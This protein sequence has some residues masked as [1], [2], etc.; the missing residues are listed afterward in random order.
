[1]FQSFFDAPGGFKEELHELS[2][3]AGTEYWYSGQFAIRA[4]YFYEH[5]TK[6]N[7][8][9]FSLG[10]GLKYNVFNLDFAYLIPSAG[11]SNPLANTMRFSLSFEFERAKRGRK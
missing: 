1:M 4:G 11:Q 8:K 5:E 10:A 9:Y 7:R 6:G 2:F 3:S